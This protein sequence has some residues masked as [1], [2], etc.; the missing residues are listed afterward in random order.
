MK[1][2]S[3]ENISMK[4]SSHQRHKHGQVERERKK[5]ISS[6]NTIKENCKR[7]MLCIV[8]SGHAPF[9]LS[10]FIFSV[11]THRCWI[12]FLLLL[13]RCHFHEKSERKFCSLWYEKCQIEISVA[14]VASHDDDGSKIQK[15]FSHIENPWKIIVLSR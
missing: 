7:K 13:L 5:R 9:N 10:V 15:S 4:N 6:K 1:N 14:R 12:K 3:L 11:S 2:L 8:S